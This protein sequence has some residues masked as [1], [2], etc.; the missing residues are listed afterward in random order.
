LEAI[1]TME[2]VAGG[3]VTEAELAAWF[4]ERLSGLG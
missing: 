4:R 3:A 1:R 2:G